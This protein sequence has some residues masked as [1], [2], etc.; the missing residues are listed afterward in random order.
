MGH[1]RA[2]ALIELAEGTRPETS[3]GHLQS[4]ESCRR[5]LVD[6]RAML[7][8]AAE[9]SVPE[10]SP[11]FWN[12]LSARVHEAVAAEGM[13]RRPLWPAAWCRPAMAWPIGAVA[14]GI[15]AAVVTMR[16]GYAPGVA[17]P[18]APAALVVN[19]AA[20]TEPVALPDDPSFDLVA[21]LAALVDWD[22]AAE[23][24]LETHVETAANAIGQLTAGERRELQRLLRE[25]LARR[26]A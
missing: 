17:I 13:P 21:D 22:V 23:P 26:G 25:E 15:V 16:V 20:G 2:E 10:P 4:C 7:A 9:V 5:R 19:E 14:I 18:V 1:L 3:A 12:H 11:L 6:L 8:A 24:G